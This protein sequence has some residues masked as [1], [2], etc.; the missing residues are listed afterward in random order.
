MKLI[1]LFSVFAALLSL[2]SVD[3]YARGAGS[4]S[5]QVVGRSRMAPISWN[6]ESHLADVKKA[7][8]KQAEY[9]K[10]IER[11]NERI[12]N[13]N[14]GLSAGDIE[15]LKRDVNVLEGK[16]NKQQGEIFDRRE[17]FVHQMK[18]TDEEVAGLM[19]KLM[20]EGSDELTAAEVAA[21]TVNR[22]KG[23]DL[24]E[25]LDSLLNGS[26]NQE[27]TLRAMELQ[28]DNSILKAYLDRKMSGPEFC[29][30][31]KEIANGSSCGGATVSEGAAGH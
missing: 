28:L 30:R 20:S 16:I 1:K 21:T 6:A 25:K 24:K 23:L 12:S 5:K 8:E 29:N 13:P 2:V 18:K 3:S 9:E 17:K 31:V 11:L 15:R 27:L 19:D 7:E 10:E 14:S 4:K 22:F 26:K